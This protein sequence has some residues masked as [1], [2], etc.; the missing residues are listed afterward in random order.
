MK[1]SETDGAVSRSH[2][3]QSILQTV[4]DLDNG[5]INHLAWKKKL[6]HTLV[7]QEPPDANNLA[8]DAHCKCKFGGWYHREGGHP[9]LVEFPGFRK[10]GALHKAMH[11]AA[12]SLLQ[13]KVGQSAI[14]T[15]D[16]NAFMDPAIALKA[17]IRNLQDALI[18][19][20]CSID[21][22]TGAWNRHWLY[23]KLAKEYERMIRKGDLCYI[24]MVDL[25]HFKSINDA[26]GHGAG[27]E[28]L[29]AT[30]RIFSS[31]LRKYDTIF[32]YGGEEFLI[33]MPHTQADDVESILN[34]LR[35]ALE[36][37]AIPLSDG[38]S[39]SVT[40]SFGVALMLDGMSISDAIES[41]DHAL[42][43]AKASGRNRV[44]LCGG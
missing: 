10:I 36:Q 33:C 18:K 43:V 14:S 6:H 17:E 20:V 4:K 29:K 42:F 32:R 41:A 2:D 26:Y 25:D 31:Q 8:E 11:D 40:A 3:I 9:E 44:Y 12:R 21:Q 19:N 7:C 30:V 27:D 13:L 22:L 35:T 38:E 39:V 24:C 23:A 5:I 1:K 37:A 34:R 28:V 15:H 16:Y